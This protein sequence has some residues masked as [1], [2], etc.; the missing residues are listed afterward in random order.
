AFAVTCEEKDGVLSADR[1]GVS[2]LV[3]PEDVV[4][5]R[6]FKAGGRDV[7]QGRREAPP[8]VLQVARRHGPPYGRGDPRHAALNGRASATAAVAARQTAAPAANV[9]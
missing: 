6:V 9:H 7:A 2:Y 5:H 4:A 3:S 1:A 8:L